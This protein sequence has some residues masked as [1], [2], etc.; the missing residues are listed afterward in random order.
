MSDEL[1]FSHTKFIGIGSRLEIKALKLKTSPKQ[2]PNFFRAS[3][4]IKSSKLGGNSGRVSD[5]R[6]DL[7]VSRC[8]VLG[9]LP[10]P[11]PR[12]NWNFDSVVE[13]V[14]RK[15]K[16]V[17]IIAKRWSI[18]CYANWF[19][20]SPGSS[21]SKGPR[22][23]GQSC[24]CQLDHIEPRAVCRSKWHRN[25]SVQRRW[26][27]R[28]SRCRCTATI[29]RKC[30]RLWLQFQPTTICQQVTYIWGRFPLHSPSMGL[31]RDRGVVMKF[32]Q[33]CELTRGYIHQYT[34]IIPIKPH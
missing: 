2:W 7:F 3:K 15:A 6:T 27:F 11:W 5:R 24:Q 30:W 21:G 20:G 18:R 25:E 26:G 13:I 8:L 28:R 14:E 9:I 4:R 1:E 23:W 34:S 19:A 16:E 22:A 33:T 17:T 12:W 32:T 29:S 31:G 10:G